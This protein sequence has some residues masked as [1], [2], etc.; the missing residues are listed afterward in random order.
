MST[1]IKIPIE[2][3]SSGLKKAVDVAVSGFDKLKAKAEQLEAALADQAITSRLSAEQLQYLQREAAKAR[4][5]FD[6]LGDA[7]EEAGQQLETLVDAQSSAQEA[8]GDLD[9]K[10]GKLQTTIG[11]VSQ[12]FG[13]TSG[14]VGDVVG[15]FADIASSFAE[16]GVLMA[17]LTALGVG[18]S[19]V[20]NKIAEAEKAAAEAAA[21]TAKDLEELTT[22]ARDASD[23]LT[24]T[25]EGVSL[26]EIR[27][28][29]TEQGA[30][31]A[32][33]FAA[34]DLES[35]G[36]V[37]SRSARTLGNAEAMSEFG[38]GQ[39]V[40]A[41]VTGA[42][43]NMLTDEKEKVREKLAAYKNA[44]ARFTL[45]SN[46]IAAEK[47]AA[48]DE[49]NRADAETI[50]DLEKGMREEAAKS[51]QLVDGQTA[52]GVRASDLLD[53]LNAEETFSKVMKDLSELSGNVLNMTLVQPD[54]ASMKAAF[55][56]ATA[57]VGKFTLGL[58]TTDGPIADVAYSM[59]DFG[60]S[61]EDVTEA[62]F[63]A[64]D[65]AN[66]NAKA[67]KELMDASKPPLFSK[68]ELDAKAEADAGAAAFDATAKAARAEPLDVATG[69]SSGGSIGSAIAGFS[70][71]LELTYPGMGM[72]A[73]LIG[74]LVDRMPSMNE[75]SA[76][77]QEFIDGVMKL[78][79]TILGPFM[80][81][82]NS[83]VGFVTDLA[84]VITDALAP[85]FN[86]LEHAIKGVINWFNWLTGNQGKAEERE[87]G[88]GS[89][90]MRAKEKQ[91]A[92]IK[93]SLIDTAIE[94]YRALME[95]T[96]ALRDV[97]DALTNI[98]SGYKTEGRIFDAAD[99]VSRSS[100]GTTITIGTYVA[101]ETL[102]PS[103]D[104]MRRRAKSGGSAVFFGRRF[105]DDE[106][107]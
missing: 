106:K 51:A 21:A 70:S 107:G 82:I 3:D 37:D 102:E 42:I 76:E 86:W 79:D 18:V 29:R 40:L 26:E 105:A 57:A 12:V 30:R 101:K 88:D 72:F 6:A 100:G 61:V 90:L 10:F 92:A 9:A 56:A 66:A 67:L 16:G 27:A 98:P 13:E 38:R 19:H 60:V 43:E 95:N 68:A 20:L 22:K 84:N 25:R 47:L 1:G 74:N 41:N 75:F 94:R 11:G 54:A 50:A 80:G 77:L 99:P 33:Q 46:T 8:A 24:A 15:G 63:A 32:L 97:S 36:F 73:T 53:T 39:A 31:A 104:S 91:D 52:A 64:I 28:R 93:D 45:I 44:L 96:T 78:L 49:Q 23:A 85:A 83:F 35:T 34:S 89:G 55:D 4:N 17:G 2:G 87:R 14:A 5:Q 59:S 103:I 58:R 81:I 62:N 65:Q 69:L 7:G 71:M 48:W